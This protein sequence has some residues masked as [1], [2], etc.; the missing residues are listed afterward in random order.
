MDE[1]FFNL[2]WE[3]H[4]AL[5]SGYAAYMLA[6]FGIRDHH[7]AIDT[8]FRAIAFGF[9]ATIVLLIVPEHFVWLRIFSAI[10][11]ALAAGLL[12]RYWFSDFLYKILR[13]SNFSWSDETPSAWSKIT[14]HNSKVYFSQIKIELNDGSFLF[15]ND[16]KLFNDAPHGPCILGPNGDIA[17]YVTHKSDAASEINFVDNVRDENYGDEITYIS[18]DKIKK[19]SFRLIREK[20]VPKKRRVNEKNLALDGD[21]LLSTTVL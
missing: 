9:C 17:L 6:Y 8:T 15:C 2:P 7:K 4:L 20:N 14:Q 18:A 21:S 10:A 16:T 19:I 11:A 13:K 12:W 3:I 5:G 1:K